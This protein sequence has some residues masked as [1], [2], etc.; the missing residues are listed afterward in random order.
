MS[1]VSITIGL[2]TRERPNLLSACLESLHRL[3]LP[4]NYGINIVVVENDSK[5]K[6]SHIVREFEQQGLP[7]SYQIESRIGITYARNAILGRAIESGSRYLI[8]VDDDE[9]VP[10]DY[11]VEMMDF[12][13]TCP[14]DMSAISSPVYPLYP[15]G[16]PSWILKGRFL[17]PMN[18][19]AE[20]EVTSAATN[21]LLLDLDFVKLHNLSFDHRFALSGGEDTHFIAQ[22]RN[23][24]GKVYWSPKSFVFDQLPLSKMTEKW[25][26]KRGFRSGT[27]RAYIDLITKGWFVVIFK[28]IP[29]IIAQACFGL[30]GYITGVLLFDKCRRVFGMRH[31]F[32]SMGKLYGLFGR[33]HKE[34]LHVHGC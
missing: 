3:K 8:Y 24:K 13:S 6:S 29:L 16:T 26:Y 12:L 7:V 17:E 10:S 5:D 21:N 18:Y 34:Y 11:L 23:C 9:L 25:F 22:L 33:L 19:V 2:A 1:N 20:T 30:L 15:M 14:S 28:V 31:L 4:R 27:T 32:T